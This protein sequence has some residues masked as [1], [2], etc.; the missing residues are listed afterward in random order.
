MGR[1]AA[2]TR[3]FMRGLKG[4]I[5]PQGCCYGVSLCAVR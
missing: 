3:T 2:K 4:A 5:S 1:L